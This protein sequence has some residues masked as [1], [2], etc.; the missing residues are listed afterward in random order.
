MNKVSR[1]QL[2]AVIADLSLKG[3]RNPKE[4]ANAIAAY[5]LENHRV[6]ELDSILRD[7]QKYW[8]KAG[9]VDVL[10]RVARPLPNEVNAKLLRPFREL[11]PTATTVNLTAVID[12]TVI[13][14]ASLE[15]AEERLDISIA[16][17]LRRFK[18]AINVKGS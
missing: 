10:A 18:K 6:A 12:P 1:Q 16:R 13:G 4:L 3:Q 9:Y 17:R 7:V 14:G 15:L 5:L 2:V 11:Y 8:A